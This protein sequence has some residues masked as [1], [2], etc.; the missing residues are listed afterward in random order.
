MGTRSR[1][2]FW[3]SKARPVRRAHKLTPMCEPI[4]WKMWDSYNL[5]TLQFSTSYYGDSGGFPILLFTR[6]FPRG[7][8]IQ[9]KL[10]KF[11]MCHALQIVEGNQGFLLCQ[12]LHSSL[13][14]YWNDKLQN[15]LLQAPFNVP[16]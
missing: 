15:S 1:E 9:R 13:C 4:F 16:F 14:T 10:I 8:W 11:C 7:Q 3:G 12:T 2:M 6:N 5:T